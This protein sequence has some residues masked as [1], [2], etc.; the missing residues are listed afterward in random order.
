[1]SVHIPEPYRALARLALDSG[2]AITRCGSGHLRWAPPGGGAPV[3]T[4]ASPS[5]GRGVRNVRAKLR[6]A[7]LTEGKAARHARHHHPRH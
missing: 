6:R 7:G 1:M 4:P 2:W 3:F 5:D